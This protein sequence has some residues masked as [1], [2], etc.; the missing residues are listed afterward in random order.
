MEKNLNLKDYFEEFL[1]L[2]P[3]RKVFEL[4]NFHD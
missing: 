4:E 2:E 3:T 1:Y